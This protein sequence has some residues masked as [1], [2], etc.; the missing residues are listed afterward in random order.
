MSLDANLRAWRRNTAQAACIPPFH[1]FSDAILQSIVAARPSSA[2]E[3]LSI[4]GIGAQKVEKYGAGILSVVAPGAPFN[5]LPSLPSK[6]RSS[7]AI[8]HPVRNL[9]SDSLPI[10]AALRTFRSVA[11]KEA[12]QPAFCIFSDATLRDIAVA[13]PRSSSELLRVPGMGPTKVAKY[14]PGIL[15]AVCFGKPS[16]S[17]CVAEPLA[18]SDAAVAQAGA[19][20]DDEPPSKKRRLPSSLIPPGQ[21][22]AQ[23]ISCDGTGT[24]VGAGAMSAHAPGPAAAPAHELSL[25]AAGAAEALAAG[26]RAAE[27]RTRGRESDGRRS[28]SE[29]PVGASGGKRSSDGPAAGD[30][31]ALNP[32]QEAAVAAAVAGGNVFFTGC[33]G[34]GKST[35]LR[36]AVRRLRAKHGEGAVAVLA[37][38]GIAALNV[39]GVTVHSFLGVGLALGAIGA[40]A[41][42]VA[43]SQTLVKRWQATRVVVIDEV[44][45]L[46]SELFEKLEAAGRAARGNGDPMGGVQVVLCGDFCQLPPVDRANGSGGLAAA[47]AGAGRAFAETGVFAFQAGAWARIAPQPFVLKEVHR[48]ADQDFVRVLADI[49]SG[50]PSA[51][52]VAD[53]Q[54]LSRPLPAAD[55]ILPTRLYALNRDV[56]A[57]NDAAVSRLPGSECVLSAEDAGSGDALQVVQRQC[58][59]PARLRLKIG[60]QVVLLRNVDARRGL[61]NGARGV[62]VSVERVSPDDVLYGST[63]LGNRKLLPLAMRFSV[64]PRVRFDSGVTELVFPSSWGAAAGGQFADRV[65][66]PLKLAWAL[67]VHRAQGMS[68]DRVVVDMHGAFDCGMVYVALSRARSRAGL[69]VIGL[70]RTRIGTHP[71]VAAFYAGIAKG[72][73]R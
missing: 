6:V 50:T 4:R 31:V 51:E 44:S 12:K 2:A 34:T 30:H 37:P 15:G 27:A 14:G 8:K 1:I 67:T 53:L 61:V 20:G 33:A 40:V 66:V 25:T 36:E 48:Q 17:A 42:R 56:D 9:D 22:D 26:L 49:R 52:T 72:H 57:E 65:Q 16:A 3:L 64:L 69:Q 71:A 11:A 55:G 59:A 10:A 46:H 68:L 39:G 54:K 7:S 62:V 38:T 5:P 60:A 73:G 45:M 41:G 35:L 21:S 23:R 13:A 47:A 63:T 70:D 29:L 43:S 58:P 18:A 32:E 24:G 28:G 19:S